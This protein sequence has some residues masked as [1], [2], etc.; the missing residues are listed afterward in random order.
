MEFL[1][2]TGLSGAG[3]NRT[4]TLVE[5]LG[6]FCVNNL[7]VSLLPTLSQLEKEQ[8]GGSERV[9]V[10]VDT[11]ACS[12]FSTVLTA[13][14]HLKTQGH[15]CSILFLDSDDYTL[16][17]RYKE[18]RR[19]HPLADDSTSL[20][21][22]IAK[23]RELLSVIYQKADFVLD[24]SKIPTNRFKDEVAHL[25]AT[26]QEDTP[27]MKVRISSFGFKHGIPIDADLVF[28]VRFLPNPFYIEALRPKT[29]LDAEVSDYVFQSPEAGI[30]LDKLKD[31]VGWLVPHYQNE[32]KTSLSVAIG[33]TGGH[34][35]SVAISHKLAEY[36]LEYSPYE[37]HRD[38]N[39]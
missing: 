20:V 18:T 5:D 1:I 24:S 12:D 34:H 26:N 7:P 10:V 39:H 11:R 23:E 2:I 14:D 36:L 29:G 37:Y 38:I 19:A 22:T 3:K 31:M 32:G 6:F 16:T 8:L 13:I 17:K 33:C 35:R 30:F 9:A 15:I 28:D 4:A 21:E 27:T 25:F